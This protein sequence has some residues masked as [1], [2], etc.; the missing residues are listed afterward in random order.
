MN[1]TFIMTSEFDKQWKS[2]GLNDNDLRRLQHEILENPKIGEVMQGTGRLRKMRFAFEGRGK[3][4]SARVT[5]VDFI[6]YNTVYL[7]YTY[8]KNEKDNLTKEERNNI[9][10]MIDAIELAYRQEGSR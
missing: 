1:R 4:G 10:K 3:S 2:M 6:L 5:Y 8:P 9:K 7:I